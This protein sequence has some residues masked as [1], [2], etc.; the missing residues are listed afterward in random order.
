[1]SFIVAASAK[2][3]IQNKRLLAL[4]KEPTRPSKKKT[5]T[6]VTIFSPQ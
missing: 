3:M 2:T 1:M 4:M 5:P 6:F